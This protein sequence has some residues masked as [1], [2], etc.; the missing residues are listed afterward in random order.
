[1]VFDKRYFIWAVI[2]FLVE[3]AIALYVKDAV[4][5]PYVG[6]FLVVMLIYCAVKTVFNFPPLKAAL[7]TL[8]FSYL[9]EALQYFQ[10]VDKLHLQSNE[11]ARTVIG[12]G[13]DWKDLIAYTLGITT[14]LF[15]ERRKLKDDGGQQQETIVAGR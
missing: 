10:I 3:V 13:F 4:V 5:R 1:M 8:L 14:L 2:L 11:L 9:L 6:D 7:G 12:Y 15:L